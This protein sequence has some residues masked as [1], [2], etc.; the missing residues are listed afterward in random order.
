MIS[1]AIRH[2]VYD[3]ES[4]HKYK[5]FEYDIYK[6]FHRVV[7]DDEG[8]PTLKKRAYEMPGYKRIMDDDVRDM[9]IQAAHK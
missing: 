8:V 5:V 4:L 2:G 9:Y 6:S 1:E 3:H 7:M